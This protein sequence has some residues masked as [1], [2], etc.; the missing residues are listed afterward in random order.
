MADHIWTY[1]GRGL[2]Y[3]LTSACALVAGYIV[4]KSGLDWH[5]LPYLSVPVFASVYFCMCY[6]SRFPTRKSRESSEQ[7]TRKLL[8]TEAIT[9][10]PIVAALLLII[11][12]LIR[13][14]ATHSI[15]I[16]L[17]FAFGLY[18]AMYAAY[19]RF[20]LRH[21]SST[22][23]PTVRHRLVWPVILGIGI[24]FYYG[25]NFSILSVSSNLK[26]SAAVLLPP[27][28]VLML[29]IASE[30]AELKMEVFSIFTVVVFLGTV[31]FVVLARIGTIEVPYGFDSAF[32]VMLFC[33]TVSAYLAVFETWYVTSEIARRS[34][35]DAI[36]TSD[37]P[38]PKALRYSVAALA[39]LMFSVWVM[40]LLFVFSSYGTFFLIGFLVHA[41]GAFM[42][43]YL[44]GRGDHL[45]SLPWGW[46]KSIAGIVFLLSV[47][48]ATI[49]R[50]QPSSHLIPWIVNSDGM[51]SLLGAVVW[52]V[53]RLLLNLKRESRKA[54]FWQRVLV[55]RVNFVFLLSLLCWVA[56][57][58]LLTLLSNYKEDSADY[59]KTELAF[60]AYAGCILVCLIIAV[61]DQFRF[62]PSM[63]TAISK[64]VVGILYLS[65]I[66]T[67]ALI[68]LCVFL[69]SMINGAG[70]LQSLE[71]A[72]PFVLA[73]IGGFALNDFFDAKKDSI[74]KPYRAIPSGK[75][76][77][78]AVAYIGVGL[79]LLAVLSSYL[80]ALNW[81]QLGLYLVAIS[82]V[83]FYN[84]L[85][86]Y[87]SLSKTFVTSLISVLPIC[88]SIITFPYPATFALLPLAAS[89]F[90]LGRE[91]LM[92]VKDISG[93]SDCGTE[94]FAMRLGS[95]RAAKVGFL[96]QLVA[97]VLL[98]PLAVVLDSN[99]A[100]LLVTTILLSVGF[101]HHLWMSDSGDYQRTVIRVL[102]APMLFGMLLLVA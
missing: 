16:T 69:P 64:F 55:R 54:H 77:P 72:L 52:M 47:V 40:P 44:C 33:V 95:K 11:S 23:I 82:G 65:R 32:S 81:T 102:W 86:R 38:M 90:V 85:V 57:G 26:S 35:A 98:L 88:F 80:V 100:Y 21:P 79:L 91:W 10:F 94:T 15:S 34:P 74:N 51:A 4:Q 17:L 29:F 3:A 66:V 12:L 42:L 59:F 1:M 19:G 6:V 18:V 22:D 71:Y 31:V 14:I 45:T 84:V 83:T 62:I 56:C 75:L 2:L 41:T 36:S 39:A 53:W 5:D 25:F 97:I 63:M 9:F 101:L 50:R 27:L 61:L 13:Y 89:F 99:L 28:V 76:S 43:W 60:D 78:K 73:A 37:T 67:S 70:T 93:D 24:G 87:V 48:L 30:I 49:L 8:E 20:L 46:I 7:A 58:I 92:D 96:F 68:G